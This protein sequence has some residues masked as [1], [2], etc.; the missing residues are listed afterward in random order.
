MNSETLRLS[1]EAEPFRPFEVRNGSGAAYM[2]T[3]PEIIALAPDGETAVV[4][5]GP[6]RVHLIDVDSITELTTFPS[7]R[8]V[9]PDDE[10]DI[11]A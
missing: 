2:I 4:F 10:T 9:G 3:H 6:G 5:P 11:T 7:R 8:K 1:C